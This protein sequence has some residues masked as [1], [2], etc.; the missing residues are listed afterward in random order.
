MSWGSV[1]RFSVPD[2]TPR[3]Q[4]D[5]RIPSLLALGK[6]HLIKMPIVDVEGQ[7]NVIFQVLRQ[8]YDGKKLHK[9]YKLSNIPLIVTWCLENEEASER[10]SDWECARNQQGQGV[11]QRRVRRLHP[12]MVFSPEIFCRCFFR[13]LNRSN[14]CMSL[15]LCRRKKKLK[16][17]APFESIRH[18]VC[19]WGDEWAVVGGS[20][21]DLS[22]THWPSTA[23]CCSD[24]W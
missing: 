15:E 9:L 19:Q 6:N 4:S 16:Q 13:I 8:K 5:F 10:W 7:F 1:S 22:P 18:L 24:K 23:N 20:G 14:F 21:W 11:R 17:K 3:V 2:T 12:F